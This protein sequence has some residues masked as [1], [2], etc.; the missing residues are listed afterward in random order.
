M[1][2]PRCPNRR[3][4]RRVAA[5]VLGGIVAL[6][7]PGVA[8]PGARFRERH[9]DLDAQERT[10]ALRHARGPAEQALRARAGRSA[11]DAERVEVLRVVRQMSPKGTRPDDYRRRADVYVYDYGTDRVAVATVDLETGEVRSLRMA[12]G[13]QPPLNEREVAR[14]TELLFTDEAAATRIGKEFARI[15]GRPFQDRREIE[16]SGFVYHADSMPETNTPET[17]SCGRHRCAQLLLRTRDNVSIEV[18][19]VDLS[20]ER[21]LEARRFGPSSSPSSPQAP[22]QHGA[23]DHAH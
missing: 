18:P 11:D 7:S 4:S 8:D 14:A 23:H 15:T 22:P 13:V 19:I 6:A 17:A 3:R 20:R 5:L 1:N 9:R 16:I 21:V 12:V 2:L 10:S